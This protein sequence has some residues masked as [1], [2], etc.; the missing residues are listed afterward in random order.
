[1]RK[2]WRCDYLHFPGRTESVEGAKNGGL[3]FRESSSARK[4]LVS[5][6][7][8]YNGLRDLFFCRNRDIVAISSEDVFC[9]RRSHHFHPCA[10]RMSVNSNPEMDV[11]PLLHRSPFVRYLPLQ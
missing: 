5:E 4:E 11:M 10:A 9:V 7:G 8:P 6:E 1:M 2:E 3:G